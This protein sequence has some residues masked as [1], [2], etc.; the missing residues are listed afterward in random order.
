MVFMKQISL[1]LWLKE[2]F[3][4]LLSVILS[5]CVLE[6]SYFMI[7]VVDPRIGADNIIN[8]M[9]KCMGS[10][11]EGWMG[12]LYPLFAVLPFSMV[13]VRD[14]KTGY[15]GNLW[16]RQ[17][18]K[19][20]MCEKIV[21]N[22]LGGGLALSLSLLVFAVHLFLKLDINA[23]LE[24][25]NGYTSAYFLVGLAYKNVYGYVALMIVV[26]FFCGA[27]YA[28]FALGMSAWLKNGILTLFLP[29]VGT[30]ILAFVM[31]S[32]DVLAPFDFLLLYNPSGS[33]LGKPLNLS[34][35]DVLLTVSGIILFLTGVRRNGEN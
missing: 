34:V 26:A 18:K 6:Y 19:K 11:G 23:P 20:Y 31:Q 28:V 21:K 22:F 9:I 17:D 3:Y 4:F 2:N 32:I 16:M 7:T 1:R 13:Y 14:Y 24:D 29:F 27:A 8:G 12:I 5:V 35:M 30:I 15:L 25:N 10:S 33:T